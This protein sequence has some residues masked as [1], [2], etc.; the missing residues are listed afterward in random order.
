[1]QEQIT[2]LRG[3]MAKMRKEKLKILL[4]EDDPDD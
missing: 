2:R 3:R 4:I 1:M